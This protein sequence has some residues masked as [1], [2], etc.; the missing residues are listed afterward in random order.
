MHVTSGFCGT[1]LKPVLDVEEDEYPF[2]TIFDTDP[3]GTSQ[4]LFCP[5]GM[6]FLWFEFIA[7]VVSLGLCIA[8]VYITKRVIAKRG[9]RIES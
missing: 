9:S 3:F 1:L 5:R 2:G 8:G 4:E 6:Y 7:S